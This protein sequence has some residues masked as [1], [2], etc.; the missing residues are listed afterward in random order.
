MGWM[1]ST[2]TWLSSQL[3][4]ISSASRC[5]LAATHGVVADGLHVVGTHRSALL[6]RDRRTCVRRG[7]FEQ[8][9]AT[10][11]LVCR[12]PFIGLWCA[13]ALPVSHRTEASSSRGAGSSVRM[14]SGGLQRR[15]PRAR[16]GL[17]G[18]PEV[19]GHRDSA[20]SHNPSQD[21]R[22]AELAVRSAQCGAGA[23]G[24]RLSPRMAQLLRVAVRQA[25]GPQYRPTANEVAQGLSAVVSTHAQ[26]LPRSAKWA[27][28]CSE[29][30]R[31]AGA[32]VTPIA[33]R[34]VIGHDNPRTRRALLRQLRR[35]GRIDTAARSAAGGWC[36]SGDFPVGDDRPQR[37]GAHG[38]AESETLAV[39]AAQAAAVGA[40]EI[41]PTERV[42]QQGQ[43]AARSRHRTRQGG[44]FSAG[45][46]PQA[47]FGVGSREP[48]DPRRGP[49]YRWDGTQSPVGA[50][51]LRR[52]LGTVRSDRE[53]EGS[54]LWSHHSFG[55][56]LAGVQQGLLDMWVPRP[57]VTATNPRL[58]V[59]VVRRVAR[60]RPQRRQ[61]Y[62]RRRAGGETKRFP[63]QWAGPRE[64]FRW[65]PGKTSLF[66]GGTGR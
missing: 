35:R 5:V 19:V 4:T 37:R 42:T 23:V 43:D 20:P 38:C 44:T 17:S 14:L 52:G 65:S 1:T 59:S 58:D 8:C 7:N 33:G 62:S 16:G 6:D 21:N 9:A 47:G 40:G 11:G 53:R 60:S 61:E 41:P 27:V 3:N 66:A 31:G 45:L 15:G 22:R 29:A 51:N 55:V 30:W 32:L 18:R 63:L 2:C 28:V 50:G 36:R 56:A 39:P 34:P 26:W 64:W 54:K 24:Q 49:Q 10:A 57:R 48:S 13:E 46:S 25:Q 12:W